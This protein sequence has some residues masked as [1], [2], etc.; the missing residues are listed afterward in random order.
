MDQLVND[1]IE[2]RKTHGMDQRSLA[3]AIGVT[4]GK[5][6]QIESRKVGVWISDLEKWVIACGQ[7]SLLQFLS[8]YSVLADMTHTQEDRDMGMLFERAIKIP[9][10]RELLKA[11]LQTLDAIVAQP[12][13]TTPKGPVPA[14]G[15]KSRG[16][17]G[18]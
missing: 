17:T 11:Y 8:K 3:Q 15:G 14:A 16:K 13:T 6:Q 5:V 9:F 18:R 7:E 10:K 4:Q 2:L 1:L 12:T